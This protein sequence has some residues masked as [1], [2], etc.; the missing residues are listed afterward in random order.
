MIHL[1]KHFPLLTN[2]KLLVFKEG[3]YNETDLVLVCSVDDVDN[4]HC[5]YQAYFIKYGTT[6]ENLNE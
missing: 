2:D 6:Y 5:S 3:D 1:Y 4:P